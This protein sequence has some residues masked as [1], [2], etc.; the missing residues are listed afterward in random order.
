MQQHRPATKALAL[1]A[2]TAS[3]ALGLSAPAGAAHGDEYYEGYTGTLDS[4]NDSGVTGTVDIDLL[5]DNRANITI[6]LA[7]LAPDLPHAQHLHGTITEANVCPPPSADTDEDGFVS[8]VEGVPF[9]GGIQTSLTTEGDTSADSALAVERFPV[10]EDGTFTYQR[11]IEVAD[12]VDTYLGNLH[13]VIHGVD[14]NGNGAYDFDNG[15]SSLT[16]D[17]PLE[18]T[19]PAACGTIDFDGVNL[20]PA[21]RDFAPGSN[22]A[23]I[24]RSYAALLGRAPD[25][26]GFEFWT[27]ARANGEFTNSTML[28]FFASSPEFQERY[29]N[30]VEEA[31]DGEW[32]DFVYQS[33]L[34]RLPDASGKAYWMDRL[35]T[36]LSRTDLVLFFAD[37][38][39]YRNRF[40]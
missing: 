8:V 19:I 36:D 17:L 4:L 16:D 2:A 3:L 34:G 28:A 20:P 24:I 37:S 38:I 1:T 25:A 13:V 12:D 7:G 33:V 23:F 32:I 26:G 31:T 6:E 27:E 18:A 22:E 21:Y 39:E 15:P 10:S 11:T 30:M 9:Y 35:E 14:I 29:G 40:G 5:T